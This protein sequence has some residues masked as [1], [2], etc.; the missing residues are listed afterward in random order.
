MLVVSPEYIADSLEEIFFD[1]NVRLSLEHIIVLKISHIIHPWVGL[2]AHWL[3]LGVLSTHVRVRKLVKLVL[4]GWVLVLEHV[5]RFGG[6][7]V[8]LVVSVFHPDCKLT[9][10]CNFF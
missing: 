3:A 7:A 2:V 6:F 5:V 1:T 8:D 4:W 9:K 10:N